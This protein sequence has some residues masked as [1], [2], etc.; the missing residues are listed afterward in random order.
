MMDSGTSERKGG[1]AS[2]PPQQMTEKARKLTEGIQEIMT[3]F[4]SACKE[5]RKGDIGSLVEQV[6]H[7]LKDLKDEFN[8]TS[9]ASP[10]PVS[11]S[12]QLITDNNV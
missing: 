9:P 5:A 1:S 10:I 3:V 8:A 12:C 2:S 4:Q 7:M 11:I 6:V